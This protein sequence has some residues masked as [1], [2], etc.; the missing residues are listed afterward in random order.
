MKHAVWLVGFWLLAL[1]SAPAHAEQNIGALGRIEPKGGIIHLMGPIG[2]AVAQVLVKQGEVVRQGQP[3]ATFASKPLLEAE[4]ALARLGLQEAQEVQAKNLLLQDNQLKVA[5][6]ELDLAQKSFANMG[7]IGADAFSVMQVDQRKNQVHT[8]Q[9]KVNSAVLE[10]ERLKQ[11]S[12]IRLGRAQEQVK[13]G[14]EKLAL[15]TLRAPSDGTILEIDKGVGETCGGA[16]FILL[17][18]LGV[19]YVTADIFEADV[20]RLR[21]GQ[22]ASISGKA[23]GKTIK[24][25]IETIGRL[26]SPQ[27]KVAKV[28]IRLA[29]AEPAS[30]LINSEVNVSIKTTP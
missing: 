18:D 16:P 23:L 25:S 1:A 4:L 14:Q 26:V 10:S 28:S 5:K 11:E 20:P 9:V 21:P 27:S 29:E 17:A 12:A 30:Q 15:A 6:A 8:A 19:M 3:L 22:E 24:G 2:E 13:L 7:Q